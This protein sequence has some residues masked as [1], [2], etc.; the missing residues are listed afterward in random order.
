VK[1]LPVALSLE[2]RAVLIVGGGPVAARKAAA[3]L[4]VGA[5]VTVVSPELSPDFP[6]V[7]HLAKHYETADLSGFCLVCACTNLP[8]IN[9]QIALDAKTQGIWCNLADAPEN[10]DFHTS[11]VV[12]RDEIAI[13]ISTS[14]LSPVLSRHLKSQIESCIGPEYGKLLEMVRRYDVPT[15][16]RGA[17]WRAVLGGEI[18][19]LLRSN[20]HS[21]AAE[22]LESVF[23][24]LE[25]GTE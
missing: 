12:R 14:G 6:P 2:N 8:E 21:L 11:A 23:K 5:L 19:E 20:E 16:Q 13:G 22:R 9:A 15:S 4:E 24:S 25:P 10:S 1:L 3:F 17:F 18:L 7:Q